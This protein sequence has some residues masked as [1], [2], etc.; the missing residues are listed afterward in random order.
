M[1]LYKFI[2]RLNPNKKVKAEGKVIGSRQ[3][4]GRDEVLLH[5]TKIKE[6][7]WIQKIN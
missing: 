4:F 1:K 5:D 6:D 2:L 3:V 7:I